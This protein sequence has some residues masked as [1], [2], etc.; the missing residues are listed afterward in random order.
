[1]TNKDITSP[2][3]AQAYVV[4][5][6]QWPYPARQVAAR[7]NH[8]RH[9]GRPTAHI[10]PDPDSKGRLPQYCVW[11]P[12]CKNSPAVQRIKTKIQQRKL[13]P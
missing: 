4:T 13:N 11:C 10:D 3:L 2:Q 12:V 1:M 9:S 8:E 6:R 5:T 7:H